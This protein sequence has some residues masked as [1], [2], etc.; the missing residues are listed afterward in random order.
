[1][2][3]IATLAE[4]VQN[5]IPEFTSAHIVLLTVLVTSATIIVV[6]AGKKIEVHK[7][8]LVI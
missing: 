3:V 4:V 1:M 6:S 5:E 8:E 2:S 7:C